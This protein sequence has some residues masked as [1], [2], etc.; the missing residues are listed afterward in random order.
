VE[1]EV[2]AVLANAPDVLDF[3]VWLAWKS[4]TA[5]HELA[6]PT[7]MKMGDSVIGSCLRGGHFEVEEDWSV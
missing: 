6:L 2:L 7:G 3:Y 4:F 1:R 5:D